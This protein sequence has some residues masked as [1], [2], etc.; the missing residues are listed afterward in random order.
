MM[1][2]GNY[3]AIFLSAADYS[4][5]LKTGI[6]DTKRGFLYFTPILVA[7]GFVLTIGAMLASATGI[8][9]Q[10]KRSRL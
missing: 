6:S 1:F 7:Y 10:L 3:A 9:I 8:P 4:R 5:E 2:M